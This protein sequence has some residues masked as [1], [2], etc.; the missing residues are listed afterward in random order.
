[1]G[2]RVAGLDHV[3]LSVGDQQAS[4]SWY[5]EVLG[6]GREYADAW[7][8]TP[9]ALMA[10]GSGLALFRAAG[11]GDGAVGLRHI[12]FR[13][14]RENFDVAQKDLRGRGIAFEFQDHGVSHSIYFQDPDGLQL[15]L[16]TYEI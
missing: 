13:V 11:N 8:D 4:E 9:V 1:M 15:E 10:Q 6:L 5:R 2:F 3:A 14:D 16:T 7:G 12:A